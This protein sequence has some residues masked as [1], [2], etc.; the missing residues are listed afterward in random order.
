MF[1]SS[2]NMCHGQGQLVKVVSIF[3]CLESVA[4]WALTQWILYMFFE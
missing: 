2:I 3:D 4:H 1:I